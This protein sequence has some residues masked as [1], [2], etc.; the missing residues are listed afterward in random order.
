[1]HVHEFSVHA[2]HITAYAL[3][4]YNNANANKCSNGHADECNSASGDVEPQASAELLKNACTK[5][6]C[7]QA[8]T[9][10]PFIHLFIYYYDE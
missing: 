4:G 8:R 6:Q 10:Y 1:M 5:Q 2:V 9:I 7:R 3:M